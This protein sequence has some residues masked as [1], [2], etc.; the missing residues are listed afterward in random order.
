MAGTCGDHGGTR[1]SDGEPCEFP[2]R[3]GLCPAHRGDP[4]TMPGRPSVYT[5]A[6]A[7][8][9]LDRM[10]DGEPLRRICRDD[11]L[12]ARSTVFRWVVD[13]DPPGFSDRFARV[14]QIQALAWIEDGLQIVDDGRGDFW[15][16]SEGKLQIEYEHIQRSKL[17][18]DYRKWLASKLLPTFSDKS[19]VEVSGPEG[20]PIRHE[21]DEVREKLDAELLRI[22][23][24]RAELAGRN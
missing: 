23:K 14:R 19:R 1:K 22:M 6:V 17:R 11:H 10:A 2:I 21:V 24:R 7:R 16:D 13:C 3:E 4:E 15:H 8:E 9:I 5:E 12:P 20:G 18:V